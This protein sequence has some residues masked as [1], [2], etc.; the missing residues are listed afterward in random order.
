MA[1][2]TGARREFASPTCF[3]HE[4]TRD[5]VDPK[6]E[7]AE[8]IRALDRLLEAE[9]GCAK[10]AAASILATD[11]P[12]FLTLF[13]RSGR[14]AA[15]H[16]ATLLGWIARLG[17]TPSTAI[18]PF[19]AAALAEADL[20]ERATRLG[21]EERH[22]LHRLDRLMPRVATRR[23]MPTSPR[24]ASCARRCSTCRPT[25]RFSERPPGSVARIL[26]RFCDHS[27]FS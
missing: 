12:G 27:I 5:Y 23:S 7:P 8:L 15:R 1:A 10:V 3:T 17:G 19:Y 4:A 11:D 26:L 14:A 22:L 6:L 20:A 13:E 24:C 21:A 25:R 18:D 2:V 9:R 16:A